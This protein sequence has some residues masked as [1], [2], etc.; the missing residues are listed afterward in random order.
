MVAIGML[1]LSSLAPTTRAA[2]DPGVLPIGVPMNAFSC[3]SANNPLPGDAPWPGGELVIIPLCSPSP[4]GVA[5]LDWTPPSGSTAELIATVENPIPDLSVPAWLDSS[6][7]GNVGSGNLE[8]SLNEH[9]G[10]AVRVAMIDGTCDVQPEPGDPC[11]SGPGTGTNMWAHAHSLRTFTLEAAHL[12]GDL[13]ACAGGDV[14]FGCLIGT[15][16]E[17]PGTPFTDIDGNPFRGDIEWAYA[18][19]ITDGCGADLFCPKDPVRRDQMAGFLD[20]MF[21]LPVTSTDYFTDDGTNSHEPAINR[22]AAAGITLGCGTARYCP[23][24]IVSREQM[25]AFIARAAALDEGAGRDYF[26][27]DD[28][29]PLEPSDDLVAAAGISNGCGAWRFC[30]LASVLREQMVAFLHRVETPITPPPYPAP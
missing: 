9:A 3:D 10:S 26:S 6:Q 25:A 23:G 7:T 22:V 15:F 21:D 20:R 8:A 1:A 16:S 2:T 12:A 18:A 24:G 11:V 29:R 28:G 4:D 14:G 13:S 30:P 5:W 27:D 19:G 17:E